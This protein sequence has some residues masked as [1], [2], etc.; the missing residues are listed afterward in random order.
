MAGRV[1][2]P[3]VLAEGLG[4]GRRPTDEQAAVIEAPVEPALV[5]AGAGAGKTETMAARVVWLVANGLVTPDRV[6]GLTFTRK[7]ARELAERV[8]SRLRRLAAAGI[9]DE[10]RRADVL[11]GEPTILTYHAY[12]GRLVGEH[13]LRLPTE[14]G[15]RLLT[16]TGAWQL[17]H[18]VVSTW[19]DDLD[20]DNVPAT[21]T[22][23]VLAV[24]GQLA[25][26]LVDPEAL[27]AHAEAFRA[28]V[29]N[30]P[31][32]KGQRAALSQ[33]L[34]RRLKAQRDR[35]AMLPIVDAYVRRKRADGVLDFGDQLALAAT[36]AV[37]HPEVGEAER[38]RYGVVLL[39][40][41]Q[42]TGHAQRVLL[43]ALFAHEGMPVTAVG[44]PCQ[45]IYGWRGASAANL[46]RFATDFPREDG[47]P[48]PIYP[49]RTSFRNPPRVLDLANAVSEPIRD[50]ATPVPG[51]RPAD[52]DAPSDV[53]VALL[54]D[55]RAELAWMAG[56]VAHA[57]RTEEDATGR[58]PTAAVL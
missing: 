26:H 1:L 33:D 31:R 25:E 22:G 57:W 37:R 50:G 43:R 17:A 36:L 18:R 6:L 48:A 14:P 44:D 52:E 19:E 21:V 8:R 7:A 40:E 42:D 38:E 3:R 55:V 41:Y 9:L 12:A 4:F 39:D 35:V 24:A 45:S 51:L 5:V 34:Q 53:R 16:E 15:A 10:D 20:L 54:P 58:P 46:P 2:G 27:A 23:Y 28:T 32:G 47:R 13:G 29:E 49:L 11:A 56:A 30:A